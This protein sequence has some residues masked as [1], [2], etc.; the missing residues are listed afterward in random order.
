M[1][2]GGTIALHVGASLV[3]AMLGLWA[4]RAMLVLM[5]SA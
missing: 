3:A 4:M 5:A 1:L 2:A